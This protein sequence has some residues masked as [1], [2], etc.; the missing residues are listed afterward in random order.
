MK[1]LPIVWLKPDQYLTNGLKCLQTPSL[2]PSRIKAAKAIL[3]KN[4]TNAQSL[5][6]ALG[7]SPQHPTLNP[8]S[9]DSKS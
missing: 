4:Q 9:L 8:N 6:Y 5:D 1:S 3:D 2:M 7:H